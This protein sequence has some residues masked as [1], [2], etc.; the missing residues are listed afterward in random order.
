[1]AHQTQPNLVFIFADQFREESLPTRDR[2]VVAPHL[3]RLIDQGV[4]LSRTYTSNPV[5]T[6]ARAS[7]ITG[8]YAHTHGLFTNNLQLRTDITSIAHVYRDH[9]Y[10]T[11][12]IGKWHIDG[13]EKP[14]FVPPG[15]RRQGFDYWAAFNRGHN[16]WDSVYYA[17]TPEPIRGEGYE[18]DYQTGLALD[19]IKANKD[20]PF[21]LFMSWGPPHTPFHPKPDRDSRWEGLQPEGVHLRPNV[22]ETEAAKAREELAGYNTHITALDQNLGKVIDAL[23][24]YGLS[25]H[26]ILVFT[27]DHGD[28]LGSLALYRKG[29]PLEEAVHIPFIIKYPDK[30]GSGIESGVLFHTVDFMPT[31]LALS[32]LPIP[33]GVQGKDRSQAIVRN[34]PE[35]GPEAVYIQGKMGHPGEFR[36]VRTK[37]HLLAIEASSL[38]TIHLYDTAADPYQLNNIAGQPESGALERELRGF[39]FRFAKDTQDTGITDRLNQEEKA[40]A[41]HE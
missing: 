13:E 30:L 28:L 22:P 1:M 32:G 24:A 23:D 40:A 8:L 39:L 14:G 12:Y 35:L 26:T 2:D 4:A 20:R 5:C 33:E 3:Q 34:D 18:P 38:A 21:C 37:R 29:Q 25:D 9:G 19:F 17:D 16:Y 11:G 41:S 31:L 10:Q 6:P 27:S 36:A 7:M 15:P